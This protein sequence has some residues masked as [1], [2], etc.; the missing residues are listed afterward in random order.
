MSISISKRWDFGEDK[1]FADK[2]K[3]LVLTGKKVATTGFYKEGR[4]HAKVGDFDEILDS[5]GKPF[6]VIQYTKVE[7][8]PFLDVDFEYAKLE[9]EG[10]KDIE[11]WR[12][13][14]RNFF[15]KYYSDFSD[16]RLVVCAQFKLV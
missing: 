12:Q 16:Q 13:S 7:L 11:E 5:N 10:E 2:L 9:G 14:H 8:K 1:K 15:S 4:K 3:D 6:C